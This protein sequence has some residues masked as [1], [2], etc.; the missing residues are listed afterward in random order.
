MNNNRISSFK[1]FQRMLNSVLDNPI[2]LQWI[3]LSFND[4]ECIDE[5]R[6]FLK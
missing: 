3:D 5:V 6:T 2:N 1:G 4:I